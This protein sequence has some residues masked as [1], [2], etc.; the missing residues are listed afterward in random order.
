LLITPANLPISRPFTHT[1]LI[2]DIFRRLRGSLGGSTGT[3]IP[4]RG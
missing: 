2:V 3:A 4:R 1:N